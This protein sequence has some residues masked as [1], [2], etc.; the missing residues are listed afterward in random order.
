ML[1]GVGCTP[2]SSMGEGE[3]LPCMHAKLCYYILSD[4]DECL[5]NTSGC[6]D[7]CMDTIGSFIC[8]CDSGYR[9]QAP[10]NLSCAG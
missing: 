2:P 9:L 8:S 7:H 10:D 1:E 6:S 5:L 4:I 3:G